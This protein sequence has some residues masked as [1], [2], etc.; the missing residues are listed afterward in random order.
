[1]MSE[2]S[3]VFSTA[4]ENHFLL[5]LP[6]H[7]GLFQPGEISVRAPLCAVVTALVSEQGARVVVPGK[8]CVRCQETETE[9]VHGFPSVTQ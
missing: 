9:K 1:M 8:P 6:P 7:W 3:Y 5:G 2:D 4:A